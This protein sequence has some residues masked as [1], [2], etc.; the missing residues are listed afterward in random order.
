LKYQESSHCF[1]ADGTDVST[2]N[3][4]LIFAELDLQKLEAFRKEFPFLND[5]DDFKIGEF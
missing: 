5:A 1:F 2:K 3:G 4:D